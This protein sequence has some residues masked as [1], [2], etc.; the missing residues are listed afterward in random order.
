MTGN[1]F[2][3][4]CLGC[5]SLKES[6]TLGQLLMLYKQYCVLRGF[7]RQSCG[8]PS[9][10]RY[11]GICAMVWLGFCA[12]LI[13]DKEFSL[14]NTFMRMRN[15]QWSKDMCW[16][17]FWVIAWTCFVDHWNVCLQSAKRSRKHIDDKHVLCF[18][19]RWWGCTWALAEKCKKSCPWFQL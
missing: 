1:I 4:C 14:I 5:S 3:I 15:A 17:L 13:T 11:F 19:D 7:S 9:F 18:L 6:D 8:A 10:I 12:S 16:K 2:S